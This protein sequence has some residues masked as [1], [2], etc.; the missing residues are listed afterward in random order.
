MDAATWVSAAALG[1]SA[2]TLVVARAQ[3]HVGRTSAPGS[4]VRV[5]LS[6]MRLPV[7]VGDV[8]Y[9]RCQ[10]RVTAAG[11][12]V[13]HDV[14]LKVWDA[15]VFDDVRDEI[16]ER[17][18]VVAVPGPVTSSSEPQDWTFFIR[19]TEFAGAS[20]GVLWN[21]KHGEG[22]FT[23]AVRRSL[24]GGDLYRWKWST[25]ARLWARIRHRFLSEEQ[26]AEVLEFWVGEDPETDLRGHGRFRYRGYWKRVGDVPLL[27]GHGPTGSAPFPP[28][29][30]RQRVQRQLRRRTD[31]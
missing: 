26:R 1:V 19:E 14:R 3:L 7:K 8:W 13:L 9:R 27:Q 22:V 25:S 17:E 6:D 29:S 10:L 11:P 12:A 20:A 16:V 15:E 2:V 24:T 4:G 5:G 30:L 31:G 23:R 21:V 28:V 18:S